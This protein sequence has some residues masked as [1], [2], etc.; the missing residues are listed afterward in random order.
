MTQEDIMEIMQRPE[1]KEAMQAMMFG[2]FQ[3]Q[4]ENTLKKYDMLNRYVKKG[5]ILF[6][7]S[8]LMELFP[9]DEMQHTLDIGRVIY[10]RGISATTT[11]DLLAGM[12]E[13]IFDL[14]PSKIFINIGSNDINS[15]GP[16]G[17]KKE[18][19]I[20]NYNKIMDQIKEKLPECEVYVMA[21]YPV[22]AKAD[23]GLD[24]S[25][26][27]TMFA[28]RTNFNI[29]EANEAVEG[30]AIE[31]EFYFIDVNEGLTDDEGNLKPKFSIEGLHLW[32]N[33]YA[34][35]LENMRI[36]L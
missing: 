20:G 35:I 10:N 21:Y 18:N 32:P 22:N 36:F 2:Y 30:L 16:E 15:I 4:K 3:Q 33:A 5:Q 27:D 11:D 31:H 34:V 14:E 25:M 26:K 12:N 13:C 19:L 17:Y 9:I 1:I 24:K 28:T 7:G 29:T 8:S 23:F 6:V